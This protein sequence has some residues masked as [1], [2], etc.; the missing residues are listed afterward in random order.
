MIRTEKEIRLETVVNVAKNMMIAAMTA[1]KGS[2]KDTVRGIILT[3]TDKDKLAEEMIRIGN[4]KKVSIFLR[5]GE[6]LKN[7]Q[8]VVLLASITKPFGM[9]DC[10]MCGY[11]N[12]SEMASAG[13]NCVFNLT[14]LGIAVGSACSVAADNRVDSRVMY[15][16][17]Q[18]ALSMGL[19]KEDVGV[20]WGI[21]LSAYAKSIYFDRDKSMVVNL[22]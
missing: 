18:G 2:G 12:C 9:S 4:R 22:D 16:A 6:N 19:F 3:G 7:S 13:G 5:D 10:S 21:P 1:P 14:D 20:C 15:T 11:E 8:C 17:G